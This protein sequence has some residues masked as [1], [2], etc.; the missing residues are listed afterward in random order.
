MEDNISL[1]VIMPCYNEGNEIYKNLLKTSKI[2]SKIT[3]CYEII[4]V[5]DGSSDNSYSEI[6][7]ARKNDKHIIALTYSHNRGKGYA[8]K[9]GTSKAKYNFITFLDADL[10]LSPTFIKKYLK[11]MNQE[12]SDVVIASKMHKDSVINYPFRRKVISLGYYLFLKLL[13]NLKIK[14]TQ[15]GLKLFK[16]NVLKEI[17]PLLETDG[18]AFDIELL[19]LI[20]KYGYK[21]VDAPIKLDF[22]RNHAMGRIKIKDIYTTFRDTIKVFFKT[23]KKQKGQIYDCHK[24]LYFFIGTEAELMK[25]Y[26]IINEA[27]KRGYKVKIIS[28]GQNIITSSPFLKKINEEISVDLTKYAPTKKGMKYYLIWFLKTRR[29]GIKILKTELK[30]KNKNN[31][32]MIVHGDTLSTLMGSLI[33]RKVKLKYAHVESGLRSYKWF[34]P[35]P[36]EIDRYFSSKKS[37]VN[38][39]QS[40]EAT[41][42]ANSLFPGEAVN[43]KYNTGIETLYDALAECEERHLK[44]PYKTDYFVFAIHRQENLLNANFMKNVSD[45]ILAISTKMPC[46]FIYHEQTTD[47]MVKFNIW[48]KMANNKNITIIGRQNY[49]N[50]INIIKNSKF[51]IGDG[52]GNQQEFYYLGKPYLIMRTKVE[53]KSEG[54]NWNAITFDN[55]FNNIDDFFENYKKYEKKP[56]IMKVKPSKIVM[57]KIDEIMNNI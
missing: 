34:S 46:V 12:N 55:N 31:C 4:C 43:T 23:R 39:C 21:I 49:I 29:Y 3:K 56:I 48:D 25:M 14:D 24:Y 11:I 28:N 10:E 32:L 13:F 57:D 18:F 36:E 47:A 17:M 37:V 15:T 53:D 26:N 44:S 27:K 22:T 33:S 51:V 2:I 20:N 45:K 52:C 30:N 38:F 35:F 54:I 16:A 5:D 8:L 41:N 6:K 7:R 50:F 1:S 19:V 9:F 42:L 40:M